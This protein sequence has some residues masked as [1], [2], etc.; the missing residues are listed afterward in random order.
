[1]LERN[2]DG[3]RMKTTVQKFK[4]IWAW[5]DEQEEAWLS[6]MA[7]TGLH[8]ESPIFPGIYRFHS[9]VPKE[10]IYRLD[11]KST[12]RKDT[13]AY[14]QIFRDAGWEHVGE[15]SGWQYFRKQVQPGETAEIFTDR[16]SKIQKYRRL[17]TVLTGMFP[18]YIVL[19]ITLDKQ[20]IQ[21]PFMLILFLFFLGF[22]ILYTVALSKLWRR[23]QQLNKP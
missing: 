4:W 11:Y 16:D 17:L 9:G 13:E 19:L 10:V 7:R 1:M 6:D 2:M 23:I 22:F 20:D 3:M 14:L 18:V 5:Q 15:M 8:L 21:E 12:P